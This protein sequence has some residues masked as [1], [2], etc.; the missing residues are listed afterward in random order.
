VIAIA[1]NDI[2]YDDET[3]AAVQAVMA[4]AAPGSVYDANNVNSD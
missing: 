3:D 1:Y 2:D 4:K